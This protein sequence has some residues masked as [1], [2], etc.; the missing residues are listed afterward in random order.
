MMEA[1]YLIHMMKTCFL[2]IT[3]L[4]W[5]YW[6]GFSVVGLLPTITNFLP[7]TSNYAPPLTSVAAL[8]VTC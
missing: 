6:L 7:S 8:N 4:L 1:S 5:G 3:L 2:K